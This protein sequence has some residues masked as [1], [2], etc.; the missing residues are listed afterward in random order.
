MVWH[1]HTHH[2]ALYKLLSQLSG[3]GSLYK[4]LSSMSSCMYI[5]C[6][7]LLY[8][9]PYTFNISMKLFHCILPCKCSTP[10]ICTSPTSFAACGYVKPHMHNYK[11]MVLNY[12]HGSAS[13]S[14]LY[15]PERRPGHE[16]RIVNW[17]IIHLGQGWVSKLWFTCV[18]SVHTCVNALKRYMYI[19]C[20]DRK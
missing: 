11:E 9:H 14:L 7:L 2:Q 4:L 19:V 10:V 16:K 1:A 17:I 6:T 18:R 12:I 3:L 8:F 15:L 20:W 5:C 13:M